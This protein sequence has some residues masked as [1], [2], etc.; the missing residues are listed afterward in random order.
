MQP[1][2]LSAQA[3][4]ARAR[5]HLVLDEPFFGNL[6]YR[7]KFVEDPSADTAWVDGVHLGYNPNYVLELSDEEL[8]GLLC[9]EVLHVANGHCWRRRWRTHE[10]W[11]DACDYAIN[12]IV[13]RAGYILPPNGLLSDEFIGKPAEIIYDL[14][15]DPSPENAPQSVP[16]AGAPQ[17]GNDQGG[18]DPQGTPQAGDSDQNPSCQQDESSEEGKDGNDGKDDKNGKDGKAGKADKGGK[19][20]KSASSGQGTS[21]KNSDDQ[22]TSG[23]GGSSDGKP[24]AKPDDKSNKAKGDSGTDKAPGADQSGGQSGAGASDKDDT[25]APSK[26]EATKNGKTS[27]ADVAADS[28]TKP[29]Q[30]SDKPYG[31]RTAGEVRDAPLDCDAKA[32]EADWKI[33]V[34]Q[35]L[36]IAT[37]RGK[38]PGG[39]KEMVGEALKPRVDWKA[40]L[41][42]FLQQAWLAMDYTWRLP[43]ASYVPYGLYLPR[44][45]SESLPRIVVT[46]D[47]SASVSNRLIAE[48]K[49]ELRAIIEELCPEETLLIYCDAIVQE[50]TRFMAG[51]ELVFKEIPGRGGTDF[52]PPFEWVEKEGADPVCL[53]YFT[54]MDGIAPKEPPAYPVLW[55]SPPTSFKA[56]WGEHV[57]MWD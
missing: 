31:Q 13:L 53:I 4:V 7:L 10:R 39:I 45:A 28:G 52:R 5:T 1:R 11:N 30:T 44:L 22:K 27:S 55:V 19:A 24:E 57:E 37:A 14:I 32:L 23:E 34:Q 29:M 17:E 8:K 18:K 26:S 47:T 46:Y 56:P 33:A 50:I 41:R 21:G 36:A 20:K 25:R 43:A 12:P 2:A 48:F 49:A 15:E 6:L 40:V 9:H 35:A 42:Q 3:R 38:V 16:Q 51:E 54:D